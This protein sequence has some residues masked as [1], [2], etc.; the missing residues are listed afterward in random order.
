MQILK[1]SNQII[2]KSFSN[3]IKLSFSNG[4]FPDL[5]KISNVIPA[6]KRGEN[7]EYNNYQPISLIPN[8]RKLME[9][10]VPLRLYSFLEKNFLLFEQ[11]CSFRKKLSTNHALIDITSKI[12]LCQ[13]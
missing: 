5:L 11:Q 2:C 1:I 8:L 4:A 9:K 7:Q 13:R 12:H 6:F 3:L 10:L